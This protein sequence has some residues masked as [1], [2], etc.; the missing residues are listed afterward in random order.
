MLLLYIWRHGRHLSET[1]P[2]EDWI[3]IVIPL[4]SCP[5]PVAVYLMTNLA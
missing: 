5:T 4:G 2:L 3:A 1:I